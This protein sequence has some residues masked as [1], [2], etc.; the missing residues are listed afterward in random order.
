MNEPRISVVVPNY[1]HARYLPDCL[2]A[3]LNQPVPLEE[4]I[5][6]DDAST[7]D[8]VQVMQSFARKFP[9]IKVRTNE[10]NLGVCQTMN[11]GMDLAQ[12]DYVFFT[13][14]DDVIKPA[15]FERSLPLLRAHP[16]A[17]LCSGICEWRY[18][19]AGL[20][21]YVGGTMP[22]KAGYVSPEQMVALGRRGQLT[23][24]AQSAIFKK[25]AL[26][27]AGGWVPE[28]RWFTD[29]FGSFVVGF[30]HGICFV[31]EVLS[32]FNLHANSYYNAA[33]SQAERR[34]VLQLML[35]L[36]RSDTYADVAPRISQSGI[37]GAFGG[38]ALQVVLGHRHNW[39]YLT[40]P[41]TRRAGR[42]C[43]EV[44]GRRILPHRL[45]RFCL[46]KFYGRPSEPVSDEARH[47]ADG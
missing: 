23:I 9:V 6:L 47:T 42:R 46:E 5:V 21:F 41:L 8:S 27:Q 15:L 24:A 43:A 1:N 11:R 18:V 16:E 44:V 39:E 36:L 12:G 3:L 35:D 34:E 7:D 10:R 45:K 26:R 2:Q 20:T 14:A 32:V 4:I 29:F 31:P 37:L 19:G 40:W 13:A 30:R 28:M 33:N 38:L 22:Q 17:G 25:S